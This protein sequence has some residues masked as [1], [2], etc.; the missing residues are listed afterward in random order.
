LEAIKTGTQ[1]QQS[2]QKAASEAEKLR[3]QA[4][5]DDKKLAAQA[6]QQLMNS[7]SRAQTPPKGDSNK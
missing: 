5:S 1:V 6:R 2:R 4:Q 3:A 7:L